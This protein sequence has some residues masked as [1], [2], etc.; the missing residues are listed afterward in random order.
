MIFSAFLHNTSIQGVGPELYEKLKLPRII[1]VFEKQTSIC[2]I[3][4]FFQ[5]LSDKINNLDFVVKKLFLNDL[6]L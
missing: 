2:G 3:H 6:D 5:I 1:M 4:K